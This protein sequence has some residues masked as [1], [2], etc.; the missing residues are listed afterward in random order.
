MPRVAL[1]LALVLGFTAAANAQMN[2]YE[3]RYGPTI[4]VSVDSLLDMPEQYSGRAVRTRG[5]F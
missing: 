2:E 4:E 5:R 1:A 3:A